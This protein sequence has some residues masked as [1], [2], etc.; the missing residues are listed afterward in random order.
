MKISRKKKRTR[1]SEGEI[2]L[3]GGNKIRS[4]KVKD[5]KLMKL[6]DSHWKYNGGRKNNKKQKK[7]GTHRK[8]LKLWRKKQNPSR[9]IENLSSVEGKE[10]VG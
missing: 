1:S 4:W 3:K 5:R 8:K 7:T 6:L 10:I 2:K 9:I